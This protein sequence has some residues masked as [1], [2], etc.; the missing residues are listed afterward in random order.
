MMGQIEENASQHGRTIPV[1]R[2]QI[3]ARME[4]NLVKVLKAL[5]EYF[6]V[7]LGDLLEGIVL[8]AFE[9]KH[10]FGEETLKR[11]AQLKEVY[12]MDYDASVSHRFIEQTAHNE[13][14]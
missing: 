9:Q 5:A 11:I 8:H 13:P 7:S 14:S 10:P 1:E 2:V 3:G 6:D 12:G 4:K